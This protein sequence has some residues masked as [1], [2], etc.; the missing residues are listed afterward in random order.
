[1]RR[2]AC[3]FHSRMYER[4]Q[5]STYLDLVGRSSRPPWL[6]VG[7]EIRLSPEWQTQWKRKFIAGSNCYQC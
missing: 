3:V 7:A 4:A 1:M 5:A 6:S 2:H